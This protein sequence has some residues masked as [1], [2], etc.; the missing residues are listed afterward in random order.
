MIRVFF[1]PFRYGFMQRALIEMVLLALATAL[2]GTLVVLRR[3][4]F[5]SDAMS[6]T[7]FPGLAVAFATGSSLL[8]GAIAAAAVSV[9]LL[10]IITRLPRL[11]DDAV[12]AL[13][14]ASFFGFGVIV[15]SRQ[16]SFN[17]DL[18][19]LLFGRLLFVRTAQIIQTTVLLGLLVLV[20][21]VVGKEL[22]FRAF[23]PAGADALGFSGPT[24]DLMANAA[25][26]IVVV[27]AAKAIGT[28]LV[29]TLL[30]TPAATARLLTDRITALVLL[31]AA[32][33]AIGAWIGLIISYDASVNHDV[34]LP[35]G[36][37]I[38]I[39]WTLAFAAARVVTFRRRRLRAATFETRELGRVHGTP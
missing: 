38:T 13:L 26:A 12:L 4:A 22:F 35:A 33:A 23:D 16:H 31:T 8:L 5:M 18:T 29:V 24:L 14:V 32:I 25:I 36:A 27:A 19:S 30:V 37:T 39:V 10:T 6:H 15:V 9:V 17:A 3:L 34:R 1:E 2:V 21:F 7:V 20:A 11:D 28:A